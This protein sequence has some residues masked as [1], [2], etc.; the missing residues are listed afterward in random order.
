[1]LSKLKIEIRK[2]IDQKHNDKEDKTKQISWCRIELWNNNNVNLSAYIY[3]KLVPLPVP[4]D[5]LWLEL[6]ESG[7]VLIHN[8]ESKPVFISST[9]LQENAFSSGKWPVVR[10]APGQSVTAFNKK[11]FAHLL[12]SETETRPGQLSLLHSAVIHIS[13]QKGWGPG[14]QR[15]QFIQCPV[16]YEIWLS[17]QGVYLIRGAEKIN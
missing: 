1:M 2:H 17:L 11:L 8:K 4:H 13:P 16:R 10:V 15:V 14:Y 9:T 3:E 7:N 5:R 12:Q 6:D